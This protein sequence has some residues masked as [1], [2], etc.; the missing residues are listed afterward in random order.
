MNGRELATS[1][2]QILQTEYGEN[3]SPSLIHAHLAHET[4]N[5]SSELAMKHH[6]YGGLTQVAPN[7][8]KQPDGD[9]YYMD[10]AS[11]EDFANY[12]AG[13]Y[14]KYKENGLFNANDARSF[15]EALKQGGYYGDTVENY[16][17]GM[18]SFLGTPS[19]SDF[20]GAAQTAT[21]PVAPIVEQEEI[22]EAS[23]EDKFQDTFYDSV[24]WGGFRTA[25]TLKDLDDQ[26][27]YKV[28]QEDIDRV[29]KELGGDYTATLW[30]CQNADSPAQLDRLMQ[31]K[32]EDLAR[33]KRVDASEIGLNTTGTIL[34]AF[35]DPLNFL[36]AIGAVGKVGKAARYA[37][38][39]SMTAA[40]NVVDRGLTQRLTGYEQDY[41]MAAVMGAFAGAGLPLAIDLLKSRGSKATK[42]AGEQLFGEATNIALDAEKLATGQKTSQMSTNAQEFVAS[43]EKAH[44][45]VFVKSIKDAT[46]A[47]QIRPKHGVYVVSKADAKKIVEARGYEFD[48]NAKGFFDD[49][50]GVSVLIKDNLSGTED[51]HLTLLHER[52]GHGL[53]YVLSDNDF[54]KVIA[55]LKHRMTVNPSPAIERAIKR[56]GGNADPEEVLGYLAEEMKPSNPLMRSIKKAMQKGMN[57]L[58]Y[59]GSLSDDDFI[60][61]LTK[62]AKYYENGKA[63]YRVYSDGSC[64]YKGIHYSKKNMLNPEQM[65]MAMRTL[66][67]KEGTKGAFNNIIDYAKRNP[68]MATPY[69]ISSSS[70]SKTFKE[71]GDR[72]FENPYMN[73]AL[74]VLPVETYKKEMSNK[75]EHMMNTYIQARDKALVR[76]QR[77]SADAK[78]EFNKQTIMAYNQKYAKHEAGT[79]DVDFPPEVW[80]AVECVHKLRRYAENIAVKPEKYIGAGY[81]IRNAPIKDAP[82]EF[83]RWID[84]DSWLKVFQMFGEDKK[85]MKEFFYD[86]I[87]KAADKDS[88]RKMIENERRIEWEEACRVAKEA[89][90]ELPELEEL[91][92]EAF[93][94][95]LKKRAWETANGWADL[96]ASNIHKTTANNTLN[97]IG[98]LDFLKDR[99]PLDTSLEVVVNGNTFSFDGNLRSFD[100]DTYLHPIINRLSGEV[101]MTTAFPKGSKIKYDNPLGFSEEVANSI[102]NTRAII[103][104]ELENKVQTKQITADDKNK[105]LEAFDF[106][107]AKLRGLPTTE[108]ATTLGDAAARTLNTYAYARNSGNMV[109]NQLGEMSGV[110]AYAGFNA[111]F[112]MLPY[113]K[114]MVT[115][116]RLGKGSEDMLQEARLMTFGDEGYKFIFGNANDSSSKMYRDILGNTRTAKLLDKFAGFAN[117]SASAASKLTLFQATTERMINSAQKQTLIDVAQWVNG[118]DFPKYRNPFSEGKLKHIGLTEEADIKAFRDGLKEFIKLDENGNLVDF[119]IRRLHMQNPKLYMRYFHLVQS[120][121]KRCITMPTIGNTNMLKEQS[122]FWKV[123]FMFKDFTMRAAHSQSGRVASNREMDDCL[124]TI[125]SMATNL[126]VVTGLAALRSKYV[127]NKDS[128]SKHKKYMEDYLSPDALV[129]T[130]F[131]RSNILGSPFSYV[132]DV[133]EATGNSPVPSIRTTTNRYNRDKSTNEVVGSYLMQLPAIKTGTDFIESGYNVVNGDRYTQKDFNKLLQLLPLQNM[134]PVMRLRDELVKSTGLPKRD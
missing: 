81:G 99:L 64:T 133:L 68:L 120:Q 56:A 39:A 30:V 98:D 23:F 129:Y 119:D 21:T 38:L 1:I 51:I 62:G 79:V 93:E 12:M 106:G 52:G 76:L 71:I 54:K 55:A 59:K 121:V 28:T 92:D 17:A 24:L 95:E 37:E 97:A 96:G 73:K 69:S 6:N 33:R 20:I 130:A 50:S 91:T 101:A 10:F 65:T 131:F 109:F 122:P 89:G 42:E 108:H 105:E 104:A 77:F 70:V 8:L 44:D 74:K 126:A 132:N 118:K 116:V 66:N 94:K 47:G 48:E 67:F 22:E 45:K 43:L 85:K 110:L 75:M 107:I 60:D 29:Q 4:G 58:G 111:V 19:F 53:K 34:G 82:D 25:A 16:T 61:I 113:L 3:L 13:Y 7:D 14:H 57:S 26:E 2:S 134:I 112:D 78:Y 11:D 32:K 83:Y 49:E 5:F 35:L 125:Y 127:I 114:R 103:E 84:S 124:A 88:L 9:N 72:F 15:A 87:Q 31:M 123:F 41:P 90:K 36:P 18:E 102:N 115:D 86:Y 100:I 46:V 128:E 80:E 27:G 40:A 117:T 63:G